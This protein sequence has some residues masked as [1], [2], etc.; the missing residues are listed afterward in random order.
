MIIISIDVCQ[1]RIKARKSNEKLSGEVRLQ[2]SSSIRKRA[3]DD[4]FDSGKSWQVPRTRYTNARRRTAGRVFVFR[5]RG[6]KVPGKFAPFRPQA[7]RCSRRGLRRIDS[8]KGN[9]YPL[10][11]RNS[12]R[13]EIL[14]HAQHTQRGPSTS[15]TRCGAVSR[16][17]SRS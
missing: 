16:R 13:G 15:E 17:I 2:T 3:S 12:L 14:N 9:S 5:E 4:F 11:G 6:E 7:G 10:T 1:S 8:S